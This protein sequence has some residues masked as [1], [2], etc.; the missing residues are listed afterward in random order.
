M[1]VESN[2]LNFYDKTKLTDQQKQA[3]TEIKRTEARIL[4]RITKLRQLY[5]RE[6]LSNGEE[7]T[8]RER[9]L[10][11]AHNQYQLATM[12]LERAIVNPPERAE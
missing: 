12:S 7:A 4:R 8:D 11:I 3:V 6:A 9:W 5:N 10:N 1:S 2:S